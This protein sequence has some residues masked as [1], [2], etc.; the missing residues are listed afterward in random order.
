MGSLYAAG[1]VVQP[2]R[3]EQERE[4][5]KAHRSLFIDRRRSKLRRER[6]RERKYLQDIRP[7]ILLFCLLTLVSDAAIAAACVGSSK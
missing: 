7:F 5:E 1:I 6:E 4:G 2:R 3:K